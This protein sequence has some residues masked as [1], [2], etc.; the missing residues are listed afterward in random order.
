MAE[1]ARRGVALVARLLLLL[2]PLNE[3]G[4]GAGGVDDEGGAAVEVDGGGD[5]HV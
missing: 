3:L 4:R 1:T 5:R 2:L